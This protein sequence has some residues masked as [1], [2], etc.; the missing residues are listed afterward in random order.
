[1]ANVSYFFFST[2]E[3]AHLP[4][5]A[6]LNKL[7]VS[8]Q[9]RCL[10]VYFFVMIF[11][12]KYVYFSIIIRLFFINLPC[13]LCLA[14]NT[15]KCTSARL[16]SYFHSLQHANFSQIG[17]LRTTQLLHGTSVQHLNKLWEVKGRW[18]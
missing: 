16:A 13:L 11:L 17:T 18:T 4:N 15:S 5:E 7:L 9:N 14:F 12:Y 2:T 10:Y 8:L 1:M 3:I 6:K